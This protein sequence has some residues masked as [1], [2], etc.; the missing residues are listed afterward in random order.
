LI[1]SL[2]DIVFEVTNDKVFTFQGLKRSAKMRYAVHEVIGKKP[3]T[4]FIGPELEEL[5]FSIYLSVSLGIN[6]NQEMQK[7]RDKRDN[8]EAMSFLLGE[9]VIGENKW[10][11]ESIGESY[12]AIDN[13]GIIFS[14]SAD[15]SLKEYVEQIGDGVATTKITATTQATT[16]TDAQ[17]ETSAA[18]TSSGTGSGETI[19]TDSATVEAWNSM[20]QDR[21]ERTGWAADQSDTT[22]TAPTIQGDGDGGENPIV[23]YFFGDGGGK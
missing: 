7:I 20:M 4:E 9:K 21:S 3:I 17:A 12:Q 14:L 2:G 23:S 1:G 22:S 15:I 16:T 18:N 8:G 6:P 10:V 19:A 5:S 13:Q 11:I